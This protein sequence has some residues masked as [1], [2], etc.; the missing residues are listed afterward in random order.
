M[1]GV[2][3]WITLHIS[4]ITGHMIQQQEPESAAFWGSWRVLLGGELIFSE[5]TKTSKSI[6]IYLYLIQK[7]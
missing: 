3:K 2:L 7:F 5:L 1:H 6:D 4:L